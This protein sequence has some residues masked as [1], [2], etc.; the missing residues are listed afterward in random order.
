MTD[1]AVAVIGGGISGLSTAYELH[2][3]GVPYLL[4]EQTNRFGGIIH[5]EKVDGFT[6]DSGPDAI[7]FDKPAAIE[8]CHELGLGNSLIPTLPPRTAFVLR[9]GQLQALPHGSILGIPTKIWP[10][11][12]SKL[13]SLTGKVQMTMDLAPQIRSTQI[14]ADESVASFFLRRFGR[15]MVDYIAEPLL[16]GIHAG[17]VNRLS[18]R[19]LFPRLV[20]AERKHG[21]VIRSLRKLKTA[22]STNGP[23]RSLPGGLEELTTSLINRLSK[24][25]LFCGTEVI[26]LWGQGPF[27]LEL[28]TGQCISANQVVLSVP[29]YIAAKLVNSIDTELHELCHS[30]PYTSTSTIVLGY[31]RSAINHPLLGTG[32][33]VPRVEKE[34]SLMAGSWV[35]SK[36]PNRAPDNHVQLRGFIGGA[37]NPE[38]LNKTDSELIQT[39][40][41]DLEKLLNISCQ[42][43]VKR[44]YR[45][46]RLN[47]QYEVGHLDLLKLIDERLE[48]L[49]GLYLSGAGFRGIGIPDCVAYGRMIG[50]TAT[51]YAL[52]AKQ[53]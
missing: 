7:L 2:Q 26:R 35:S 4:F 17:D 41:Y 24:T 14:N 22:T 39:V 52:K 8:L 49:P 42:P 31:P 3:H 1:I 33:V 48:S 37:R 5:T 18:M 46:S 43:I 32:F 16:A 44:V 13:L 20:N 9:S 6:I 19:A 28:N 23:F 36:W 30:I 12:K 10:L 51:K 53:P 40:H 38:A 47:P 50:L 45:W 34:F 11:V 15:E 25:S 21:S 29:A 27:H